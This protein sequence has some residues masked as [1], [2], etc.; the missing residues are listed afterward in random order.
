MNYCDIKMYCLQSRQVKH[1]T[2][3]SINE[4]IISKM[5]PLVIPIRERLQIS[6]GNPIMGK[7]PD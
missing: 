4:L 2:K 1:T 3:D 6:V 7:G 5:N